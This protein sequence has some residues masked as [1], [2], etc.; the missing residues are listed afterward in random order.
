M[1]RLHRFLSLGLALT[2]V[3]G[4][5]ACTQGGGTGGGG[6]AEGG[7]RDTYRRM[8]ESE[9]TT[10][11][12]LYTSVQNDYE[13]CANMVDCLVEY[14]P[15]GVMIPSLAERWEANE[16]NTVWTFHIRPGV[17]WVDY[18]GNEVADVTANDWVS[19]AKWVN[20]AANMSGNQYMYDGIVKNAQDYFEYTAYL[21]ESE[22]GALTTDADGNPIEVVEPVDF[23]TVGVKAV[24]DLTLEY[25]MEAPIPY[26][27]SV[28]SYT[29]YMPVYG[30]FLEE[31]GERFGADNTTVLYNG[32]FRMEDF[33]PQNQ[34]ILVKNDKYWDLENVH[35]D[36]LEWLYNA[37]ASTIAPESFLRGEVDFAY[38]DASI[39]AA[40][41]N[42]P[43]KKDLVSPSRPNVSFSYFY[44][45]N[46]EPR[47][48][49]S[50]EPDNWLKAVNNE[51]FRLSL[52]HALD[53]E[54]ALRV[55]E[56]LSPE[57]IVTNT[58]TPNTFATAAGLDFTQYPALKTITA[59]D[60]FDTGLAAQYK[61]QA[62]TELTAAGATFPVK[63][64]MRYNPS[65]ANWDKECQV[66]EQ[67]LEGALGKD[68]IDVI[69]EAGPATNYL[70]TV[71]R[72]GDFA[73]MKCNWG[74]DY[75]DPQTWTDPF[76]K[77]NT[78][79][80]M[81]Q[82][83]AREVAG[84]PCDSKSPETQALVEE[85]YA[86]LNTAKAITDDDGARYTAFAAAEAFLI[87]HGF[88]IPFHISNEGYVATRL[89]IFEA[90]YAPY[91]MALQRYKYQYV[92]ED[93][94]TGEKWNGLYQQWLTDTAAAVA[95]A[96]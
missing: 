2:L 22:N 55:Q 12:Y 28:L 14:D 94:M 24:D 29:S 34:R 18:Q 73:L 87:E 93:P 79:N 65:T 17:K 74:A 68:Y 85:Y 70:G 59:T 95:S 92:Y 41:Q 38:L 82:D 80:F 40:W 90:Q 31:M 54:N 67:Q 77:T 6:K 51:N 36:K 30:P 32:P 42:D 52:V 47:F 48:A 50:L 5:A 20:D 72:G 81:N 76:G 11:N 21:V 83:A 9:V 25:T 78:Y 49:D 10:L 26:F 16:D 1:K 39:M 60:S 75:A 88:V 69:V 71:R 58:V 84:K 62:M 15:Y 96:G 3:T 91:G 37:S 4:L 35:I 7:T 63:V 23:A 8:Y 44:A 45:F 53:R 66:V 43:A 46:F 27:P 57:R 13:M 86:L 89:N 56:P 61:E 64:Y 33:Q 19:A